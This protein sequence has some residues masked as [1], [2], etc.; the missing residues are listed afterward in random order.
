MSTDP[1]ATINDASDSAVSDRPS[2]QGGERFDALPPLYHDRAFWGMTTTQFLG[3]FNDN[4]FKQLMLLL[5]LKVGG[6]DLQGVAM[7][8]FSI[9]FIALSGFA[10]YL[11]DRNSKRPI[12]IASKVAEIAVMLLGLIGFLLYGWFGLPGLMVVLFLMGTQSTFFGPGKYGILPEMLRASDLPRANGAIV[13]TTFLAIIFGTACAGLLTDPFIEPDFTRIQQDYTYVPAPLDVADRWQPG[14]Q[15]RVQVKGLLLTGLK[16]QT[17]IVRNQDIQWSLA[18]AEDVGPAQL[19]K[20]AGSKIIVT[21]TLRRTEDG[22][23]LLAAGDVQRGETLAQVAPELWR[24]SAVCILIAVVGT[25][26]AMLIRWTPPASPN[27]KLVLSSMFIPPET[28]RMLRHDRP[29]LGA[30]LATCA[31][32]MVAGITQQSVNSLGKVQL[33]LSDTST[34]ILA[35]IIGVGIALGALLGGRLCRGRADFRVARAGA[36]GCCLFLLVLGLPGPQHGHLLGFWGS[37]PALTLLGVSAGFF[38]IPLQTFI[39]ARPPRQQKGRIIAVQ[40][41][42]NFTAILMSGVLYLGF[43]QVVS[44]L[45]WQRSTIFLFTAL[46]MLPVALFYR[47]RNE[48]QAD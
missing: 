31:F 4:L 40:N 9:P 15:A 8:V 28:R 41:Q 38:A 45:G 7:I 43:D 5:S 17:Y 42:A 32:W 34:S 21:G 1:A 12:I 26:T 18:P 3:A 48:P 30:L 35:A 6:W 36:C 24:G 29:L 2:T 39:Q 11:S 25:F 23:L 13:M 14:E 22:S 10:G 16:G 33:A 37:L 46:L 20:L 47:P 44:S 19:D 27:L